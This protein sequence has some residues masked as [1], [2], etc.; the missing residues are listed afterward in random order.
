MA[1]MSG[2]QMKEGADGLCNLFRGGT[3][4][5]PLISHSELRDD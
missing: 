1:E 4:S 3:Q 5:Q 2:H